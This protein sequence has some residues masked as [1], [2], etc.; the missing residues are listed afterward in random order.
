MGQPHIV[1]RFLLKLYSNLPTIFT[2]QQGQQCTSIFP[3][4]FYQTEP[5]RHLHSS[6]PMADDTIISLVFNWMINLRY[7]KT[8]PYIID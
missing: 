8:L 6:L 5:V 7:L 1:Q 3:S 2:M 4:P